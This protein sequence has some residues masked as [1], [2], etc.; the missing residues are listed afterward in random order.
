MI[1]HI[2]LVAI[3]TAFLGSGHCIGMCGP[4]V[5]ALSLSQ[6]ESRS[7]IGFQLLYN[8]GR[9]TTYFLIGLLAGWLGTILNKDDS[10]RQISRILLLSSDLFVILIGFAT[11][12]IFRSSRLFKLDWKSPLQFMAHA[13]GTFR[14]FPNFVVALPLGLIMG[15]LPCGFLYAMVLISSNSGS[16]LKGG[17]TMLLFGLGTVPALF[18]FGS[19]AHVFTQKARGWMLRIAGIL[20]IITGSHHFYRHL[21]ASGWL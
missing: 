4:I 10:F 21:M 18:L 8:I 13:V 19:A 14:A 3:S 16:A 9:I 20:V 2:Y 12:D 7:G 15:F 17:L 11:A 6:K 5:S 1:D